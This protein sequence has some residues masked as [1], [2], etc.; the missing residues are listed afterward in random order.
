LFLMAAA[1]LFHL[2]QNHPFVDGNKRTG[3]ATAL[4]F[5]DFNALGSE[6]IRGGLR[7]RRARG[8]RD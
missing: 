7:C 4:V 6:W 5:L 1:Y 3:T 2:V 8:T